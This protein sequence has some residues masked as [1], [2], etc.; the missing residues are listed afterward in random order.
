MTDKSTCLC[1]PKVAVVMATYNGE[2][3][4]KEQLDS[5]LQQTYRNIEI[6]IVDDCSTDGTPGILQ[7]YAGRNRGISIHRNKENIGYIKNFEK[8][9]QLATAEYIALCDQDDIW[10]PQKIEILMNNIQE[11]SV[12][13]CNS[14]LIDDKGNSLNRK[15]T[16]MKN[17]ESYDDCL[18][19]LIGNGVF[20]HAQLVRK[21]LAVK[22]IP[23]PEDCPHDW[24]LPF[25]ASFSGI[26][27]FVDEPLVKYRQHATNIS[28]L[29]KTA[30]RKEV[31]KTKQEDLDWIRRRMRTLACIANRFNCPQKEII[32]ALSDCYS[33]FSLTNNFK[34]MLL[35]FKYRK[36]ITAFKKRNSFRRFLFCCKMFFK[37]A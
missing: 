31:K 22:A 33:G 29:V 18:A 23:F 28:G 4:L 3:F 2:K 32:S 12:V 14:E 1:M 37:I 20:G 13:Y 7:S 16:D 25:I 26:V 24:V 34:R 8:A 36:S 6:I 11:A 10:H 15:M 5:I 35:F 21:S 19:F 9:I 17:L 27:K 30:D